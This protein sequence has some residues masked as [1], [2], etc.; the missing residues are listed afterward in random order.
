MPLSE[1]ERDAHEQAARGEGAQRYAIHPHGPR[2]QY[3][4]V[5]YIEP[6]TSRNER[7][8]GFD[9]YSESTRRSALQLARDTAE[10]TITSR[11]VLQQDIDNDPQPG[12]LMFAPMYRRRAPVETI[13]QRRAALRGYVYAPFRVRDL[14]Q[15]IIGAIPDL[16]VEI[17]DGVLPE[18]SAFLYDSAPALADVLRRDRLSRTA[19]LVVLDRIW[20][21]RATALPQFDRDIDRTRAHA[22]LAAGVAITAMLTLVVWVL[23]TLRGRA[24]LLAEEM[25][26]QL[27]ESRE[28]LSL[29]LE[30]SN[31][32][33]FDWDLVS[34]TV[35]LSPRWNALLGGKPAVTIT[36]SKALMA[37]AYPDDLPR[38]EDALV[39]TLKGAA[40]FYDIEHR[41]RAHDGT[42]RW[43]SSHAKVSE[44][45]ESG[46]ALRITGTNADITER[47]AVERL[48]N[49]FI[50]TVSHELR[51]PLTA[52]MGAIELLREEYGAAAPPAAAM[53][54]DMAAQNAERLADLVNHILDLEKVESGSLEL[55]IEEI[56]LRPFLERALA[57]NASYAEQHGTRFQLDERAQRTA[58]RA[59]ADRLMQV[60]TNLLS[61]AAKFSPKG[62]TVTVTTRVLGDRVRIEVIDRGPGV[63]EDFRTRI[64][65]KFAQA[66]SSD[67]GSKGGTGLA[68]RSRKRSSRRW[69][70][71]SATTRPRGAAR[72]FTSTFLFEEPRPKRRPHDTGRSNV[73]PRY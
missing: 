16:R 49:E 23:V 57:L 52:L 53:F 65:T 67:G 24:L 26:T 51:T 20:T 60:M 40:P 58:V 31:L 46:R 50:G 72:R 7:V 32:A 41:V 64:F 56:A 38:L 25:T 9:M 5:M 17:F 11:V 62:E 33:L 22:T 6:L 15:G 47:K 30:G 10:P 63:P 2:G 29:A 36:T 54:L 39:R 43:I 44:R 34:D 12:F 61:N 14:M 48:K 42:W 8:L 3:M 73:C 18:Q 19:Q 70:A 21:V 69:A 59:D 13:E 68:L 71:R 45:A 55:K 4:P 27:R 37:M 66:A 28:R 35:T 1:D